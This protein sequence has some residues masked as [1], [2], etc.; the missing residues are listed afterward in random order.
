MRVIKTMRP[1]ERGTGRFQ[2]RYGERLCA[3]R[4]RRSACGTRIMTTVEIIVDVREKA[5]DGISHNAVHASQ[6]AEPVALQIAY[7]ETELRK[8]VKQAGGRWSRLGRAWVMR[9]DTA[10]GL[11]LA[12]RMDVKLVKACT[13]IDTSF[14]VG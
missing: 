11:G 8:L 2:R 14:E 5:P 13:D 10:V 4:Y 6:R 12:H 3:V 7:D 1:G 9:R